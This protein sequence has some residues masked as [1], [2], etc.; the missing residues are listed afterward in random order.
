MLGALE[1]VPVLK[2]SIERSLNQLEAFCAKESLDTARFVIHG[3]DRVECLKN[4][5]KTA[6]ASFPH[7]VCFAN[8]L[9]LPRN[10]WFAEW[11]H[12][13]TALGL[14][15]QLHLDGIPLVILPIKLV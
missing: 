14:Q 6:T 7:S 8:T 2:A 9:I 3:T 1:T 4:L 12:N 5:I 15:R 10:R 11:L 13:Q